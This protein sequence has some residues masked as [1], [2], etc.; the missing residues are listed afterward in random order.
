MKDGD[1]SGRF[2]SSRSCSTVEVSDF[3]EEHLERRKAELEYVRDRG[4]A[5]VD[6]EKVDVPIQPS[7]ENDNK[8]LTDDDP[9][10]VA[11]NF[12]T[13]ED[14][15]R[16]FNH[17]FNR[18]VKKAQN[19]SSDARHICLTDWEIRDKA[20]EL[21]EKLCFS[22]KEVIG[23]KHVECDCEKAEVYSCTIL[24]ERVNVYFGLLRKINEESEGTRRISQSLDNTLVLLE[25]VLIRSREICCLSNCTEVDIPCEMRA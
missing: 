6:M 7:T 2:L 14:D 1:H 12:F 17:L 13:M 18:E 19:Y 24:V 8:K 23:G 16:R 15:G 3:A 10:T 20:E 5:F 4:S 11:D 25:D 21:L 22:L 9:L